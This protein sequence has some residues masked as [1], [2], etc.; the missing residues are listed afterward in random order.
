MC[1]PFKCLGCRHYLSG[2]MFDCKKKCPRTENGTEQIVSA[3]KYVNEDLKKVQKERQTL[4]RRKRFL[5][6]LLTMKRRRMIV[7]VV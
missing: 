6:K 4:I 5:K 7:Y 1:K 2:D 3:I